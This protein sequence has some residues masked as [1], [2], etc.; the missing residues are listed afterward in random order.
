MTEIIAA[1]IGGTNARFARAR[2]EAG[3]PPVLGEIHR[4]RTGEFPGLAACWHAFRA[5]ADEALPD[6]MSIAV[7][8]AIRDG[9]VRLTN[10]TWTIRTDGLA[11]EL[12]LAEVRVINDF[13]A[14][15]HAIPDLPPERLELLFGP[16]RPLPRDGAVTVIG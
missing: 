11:G 2:V 15:A 6:R 8:G 9:G 13:A 7:A 1:D 3:K 5:D 10:S 4:Y 14:V 12:G 16:A